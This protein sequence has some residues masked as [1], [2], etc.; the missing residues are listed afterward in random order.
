MT[1]EIRIG[2]LCSGVVLPHW[3]AQCVFHL[4]A[5]PGVRIVAIGV[6]LE[7]PGGSRT[8]GPRQ[9]LVQRLAQLIFPRSS[10]KVDLTDRL[11]LLPVVHFPGPG[12]NDNAQHQ[13][14]GHGAQ[15]LISFLPG[16]ADRMVSPALPCWE[17]R[18][19]GHGIG[20][21][22]LPHFQGWMLGHGPATCSLTSPTYPEVFSTTLT[23]SRPD[24]GL[25]TD[26]LLLC[27]SW[28]PV[29]LARA[30]RH[31]RFDR[32]RSAS[33]GV[34]GTDSREERVGELLGLWLKAEFREWRERNSETR[35]PGEWN[36]GILHQSI[37][38]LLSDE[39][40][41]N[42]RWLSHPSHGSHR[43]EPFGYLA[44]D[45]QLNVLYRKILRDGEP[46]S[47]ARIRPK[48]DGVLKRS[49]TMLSTSASLGYP[50]VVQRPNGAHV[51][52]S[53]PH[54]QRTELFRVAD[55]N[56]G[57]DHVLTLLDQALVNPTCLEYQGRWWLIGTDVDA[58]DGV[59]HAFHAPTFEGPY[60]PHRNDPIKMTGS[61]CRPAGTLFVH[62]GELWRPSLDNTSPDAPTVILN[63]VTKLDPDGFSEE[64]FRTIHGFRGTY[65]ANGIRS[66]CGMGDITLIDGYRAVAE[67]RK[68]RSEEGAASRRR[69]KSKRS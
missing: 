61:K 3:Q 15:W 43:V 35:I 4:A 14:I 39:S 63:R 5:Q 9:H 30:F 16:H 45:G 11:A 6:P 2:I 48:G 57:L 34:D 29:E 69:S 25:D 54:Q 32:P 28:L 47:I 27:S 10:A 62:G 60:T 67:K 13:F 17:F 26:A 36:I 41:T 24:G 50:F 23:T 59:L 55:T 53:Y 51:V 12:L 31:G 58:P 19:N 33:A 20:Q 56:D 37:E 49:R 38:S 22:G 68:A 64:P 8:A 52:I 18:F 42:V 7:Q 46:D 21:H 65:Y 1:D 44:P 66:I 40:S